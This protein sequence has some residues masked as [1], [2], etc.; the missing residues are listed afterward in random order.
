MAAA[1]AELK[2]ARNGRADWKCMMIM[3]GIGQ[4]LLSLLYIV[5]EDDG[6]TSSMISK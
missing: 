5:L 2:R 1:K 6:E 3:R 4:N